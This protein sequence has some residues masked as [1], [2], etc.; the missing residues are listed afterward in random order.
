MEP[1]REDDEPQIALIE[2]LRR[3]VSERRRQASKGM[4]VE[5]ACECTERGCRQII[6]L[7]ADEYEYIRRVPNRLVVRIGHIDPARER[8]IIEEPGR[9]QVLEKF[10]PGD[11]VV[12]HI[13]PRRP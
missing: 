12:A 10:G 7:K 9:Y 1:S 11:D 4:D 13:D 3:G 8:V 5:I 6:S 2:A